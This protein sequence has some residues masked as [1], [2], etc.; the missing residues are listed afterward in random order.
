ME[1][2]MKR[3]IVLFVFFGGV[4]FLFAQNQRAFIREI[5]GTVELKAHGSAD[6]I[7]GKAGDRILPNTVISTGFRSTALLAIDN[8]TIVIRPLTRLT[9]EELL[10]QDGTEQVSLSLRT[11][12]IRANVT[13][14]AAGRIDFSVRS[15]IA[16]ASVRGTAFDF[17]TLNLHV[18]EGMVR[19]A[20]AQGAALSRPALVKAGENS[21]IDRDSGRA[22]N[23]LVAAETNRI[24]PA[25]PGQNASSAVSD[26]PKAA[27]P[28]EA[29]TH[30]SLVVNVTLE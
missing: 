12:R 17:D 23:P 3:M 2:V 25:L 16:T 19:F 1:E 8:S 27:I 18:S 15:P 11:G 5:T 10:E 6:W 20:P 30:G 9:L 7:P 14:P 29:N 24:P 28:Q 22:V 13:P 4:S 21:W 26:T